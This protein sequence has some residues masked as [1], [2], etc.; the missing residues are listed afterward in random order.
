M[1]KVQSIPGQQRKMGVSAGTSFICFP[2]EFRR[3]K[4]G[5]ITTKDREAGRLDF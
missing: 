2:E 5:K 3:T 4:K 1:G